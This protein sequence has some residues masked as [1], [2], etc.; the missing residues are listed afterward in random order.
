MFPAVTAILSLS[1][2]SS[3]A[4]LAQ[5]SEAALSPTDRRAP[6][7]DDSEFDATIPS[8]DDNPDAPMGSVE[9][10]DAEQ[11]RLER[12]TQLEDA[13]DGVST[14]PAL[15]DADPDEL[16]ADAPVNDPEID[17]PLT[18]ID[19]FDVEPFDESQYTEAC[20]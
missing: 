14:L 16:I 10:W 19:S 2:F 17:N 11:Q 4:A 8:I 6:I 9:D 3:T 7:I 20:R 13:E 18:P 12:E 1:G 15:Q 5:A